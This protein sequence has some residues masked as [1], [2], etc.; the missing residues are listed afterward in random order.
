VRVRGNVLPATVAGRF[1][2]LLTILR[3]FHLLF[4]IY[5]N[6]ELKALSPD[7]FFVDQLS[8]GIP[9]MRYLYPSVPIFFYCHFPDLLLV[10]RRSSLVKRIWRLPFDTIEGWS[11]RGADRVVVNSGFTRNVVKGVWKNLG[12]ER[13]LGIVYPCVDTD[14]KV[15]AEDEKPLWPGRKVILSI[16]RFER[17]KDVGLAIKAFA[18]LD[19]KARK[20]SKLVIAGKLR[21]HYYAT[22]LFARWL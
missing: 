3:H 12:G 1:K 8:A 4:T 6:G 5:L 17:K 15:K 16:N 9:L 14:E 7:V 20:S 13:G 11:M 10:Q 19:S 2:I 18:A 21:L 22:Y